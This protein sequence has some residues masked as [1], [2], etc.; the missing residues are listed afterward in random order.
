MYSLAD[1]TI[2]VTVSR[3]ATPTGQH[4]S[5]PALWVL[6]PLYYLYSINSIFIGYIYIYITQYIKSSIKCYAYT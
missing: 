5:A 1:Q 4:S 2:P 6:T 3:A